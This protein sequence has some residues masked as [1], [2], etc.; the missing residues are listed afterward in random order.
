MSFQFP[1]YSW[2]MGVTMISVLRLYWICMST[3]SAFSLHQEWFWGFWA[4]LLNRNEWTAV[5]NIFALFFWIVQNL[6]LSPL[7][8]LLTFQVISILSA[9]PDI[10]FRICRAGLNHHSTA[11]LIVNSIHWPHTRAT[12]QGCEVSHIAAPVPTRPFLYSSSVFLHFF[13]SV[14]FVHPPVSLTLWIHR[15]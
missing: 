15:L 6:T 9:A 10:I 14:P 7:W 11:S 4:H 2:S 3:P 1:F 5:W 8:P 12:S 13:P